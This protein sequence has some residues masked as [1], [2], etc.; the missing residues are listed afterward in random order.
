[1][2]PLVHYDAGIARGDVVPDGGKVNNASDWRFPD[3]RQIDKRQA[4]GE[5]PF[6]SRPAQKVGSLPVWTATPGSLVA[7]DHPQ[8]SGDSSW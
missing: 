6:L 3:Y 2:R 8:L 5:I 7:F 1:M 4:D